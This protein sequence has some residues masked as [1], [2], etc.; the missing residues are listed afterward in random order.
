MNSYYVVEDHC[1]ISEL[2]C[3]S[4]LI[5]LYHLK[6]SEILPCHFA[7]FQCCFKENHLIGD[8]LLTKKVP[9]FI[10]YP[11]RDGCRVTQHLKL[12]ELLNHLRVKHPRFP[13]MIQTLVLL[14]VHDP[15]QN[16][17]HTV[18]CNYLLSCWSPNGLG[19]L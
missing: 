8:V 2:H 12:D 6:L 5:S 11:E 14:L 13:Q 3:N 19:A 15:I 18:C 10:S 16:P 9:G 4:R 1:G 17:P 7:T